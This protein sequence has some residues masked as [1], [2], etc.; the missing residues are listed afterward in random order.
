MIS[1]KETVKSQLQGEQL[2]ALTESIDT[3][4]Q[5]LGQNLVEDGLNGKDMPT[6]NETLMS[7]DTD[8]QFDDIKSGVIVLGVIFF[9]PMVFIFLCGAVQESNV[10]RNPY[11]AQLHGQ[12]WAKCSMCCACQWVLP[13]LLIGVILGL[14]N[15]FGA[16]LCMY[17][18]DF[19][20]AKLNNTMRATGSAGQANSLA[21]T[22]DILDACVARSGN[23]RLMDVFKVE[24]C[25]KDEA[26]GTY[27]DTC[28]TQVK[29]PISQVF[30]DK[31]IGQVDRA[32]KTSP[33][34]APTRKSRPSPRSWTCRTS[35]TSRWPRPL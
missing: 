28:A 16:N 35:L 24:S 10:L 33:S 3:L 18:D 23:G 34:R 29:I 26:T 7:D 15:F 31:L 6:S 11:E 32:F 21:D 27:P 2:S 17:M 5:S 1:A 22:I 12:K 9:I 30:T 4:G 14:V 8:A 20:G 25:P 19:S 13:V